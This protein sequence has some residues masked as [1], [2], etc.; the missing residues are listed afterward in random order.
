VSAI[1]PGSARITATVSGVSLAAPV[2]VQKADR[3]AMSV[4][5][6]CGVTAAGGL[7]CWGNNSSQEFGINRPDL[8]SSSTPI[9]AATGVTFRSVTAGQGFTC[10][11]S[12]DQFA[13]CWGSNDQGQLGDGTTVDRSLPVRVAGGVKFSSIQTDYNFVCGLSIESTVYCWGRNDYGQTGNGVNNAGPVTIPTAVAGGLTFARL[14]VGAEHACGLLFDGSAYCW[15]N[16]GWSQLGHGGFG[17]SPSWAPTKVFSDVKFTEIF[18]AVH[19]NCGLAEDSTAY[20]WGLNKAGA[21]GDGSTVNRNFAKAVFGSQKFKTA[22]SMGENH[23][24]AIGSSTGLLCWGGGES[25][26]I[27]NGQTSNQLTPISVSTVFT[28]IDLTGGQ[29]GNCALAS[30]GTAYCWGRNGKGQLGDGSLINRSLPTRG[31]GFTWK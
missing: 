2:S 29:F 10:G 11:L 1:K 4:E 12:T 17:S 3:I 5:H 7:S 13:Y 14:V 18:S 22:M 20:C 8:L 26:Q 19:H 16:G 31:S 24:C 9:P 15:G 25:G 23:T 27:G 28:A 6:A 21:L 30:D